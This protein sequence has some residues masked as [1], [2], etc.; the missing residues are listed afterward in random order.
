MANNKI[1]MSNLYFTISS[2]NINLLT[3]VL[4]N[5]IIVRFLLSSYARFKHLI[6]GS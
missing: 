5:T 3:C 1:T 2:N 6:Y 4:W